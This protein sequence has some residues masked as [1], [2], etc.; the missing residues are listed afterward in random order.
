MIFVKFKKQNVVRAHEFPG[1]VKKGQESHMYHIPLRIFALILSA[2]FVI[3]LVNIKPH[4][5]LHYFIKKYSK[6]M[7]NLYKIRE[8]KCCMCT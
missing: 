8:I 7:N 6:R 5:F 4:I 3:F 2:I 1:C